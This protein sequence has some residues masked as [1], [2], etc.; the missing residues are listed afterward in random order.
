[1]QKTKPEN[2][3]V[4]R[5]LFTSPWLPL[6]FLAVFALF[7]ASEFIRL[8]RFIHMNP[9]FLQV[10]NLCFLAVIAARF[11]Y[12]LTRSGRAI[13]SGSQRPSGKA[14]EAVAASRGELLERLA[15]SGFSSDGKHYAEKKTVSHSAMA[16]LYGG[17]LLALSVG[18]YDNMRQ[19]SAVLFQGVG[20]AISLDS[21]DTYLSVVK[22]PLSSF[23]GLPKFQIKEQIAPNARWPKGAVDL[24]LLSP[25][26]GVLVRSTL[27]MNDK[28]LLYNGLEY[29]FSRYLY[30]FIL[31]VGTA[32]NHIEYSNPLKFEPLET[33]Q[34]PYSYFSK[35]KGERLS[36][37]ALL[38][39]SRLAIKLIG[40]QNGQ[41]KAQS[42]I[43]FRK[44]DIVKFGNFDV[45]I[46]GM[47]H[48][49]EI[50][51]VRPRHMTP[52]YLGGALAL[53][54]LL[55]RLFFRPQRVWL[56]ET[57]EGCLVWAVG[58]AAKSLTSGGTGRGAA[59]YRPA[60]L[61]TVQ[62]Q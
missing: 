5:I 32:N 24:A 10:N 30:D 46:S 16:L 28:P 47:S 42:E 44:D 9:T 40:S 45:R 49:S 12:Y 52:I 39:P 21:Q 54:G 20:N 13:R 51:V 43:V 23:K 26:D 37:L 19:F 25:K 59:G 50:H 2:C 1:M 3:A 6:F 22:G 36:W 15:A 4:N 8:P 27:G 53:F 62:G 55:L 61:E 31:D 58:A 18:S 14:G 7:I 60:Q 17:L 48:W 34:G 38:D 57:P 29:H 56:E 41:V 11:C 33:P 35:F